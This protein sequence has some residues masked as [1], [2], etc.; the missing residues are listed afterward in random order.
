MFAPSPA[1]QHPTTCV[2]EQRGASQGATVFLTT[3][4]YHLLS[5]LASLFLSVLPPAVK[6]LVLRLMLRC[7]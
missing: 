7:V 6:P 1:T 5:F 4:H 2:N 3:H